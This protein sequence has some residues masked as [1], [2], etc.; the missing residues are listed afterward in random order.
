MTR[1]LDGNPQRV[2]YLSHTARLSGAEIGLLRFVRA[3]RGRVEATVALAEDGDLVAPLREAGARVEVLPLDESARGLKRGEVALGARQLRAAASVSRY[4]LTLRGLIRAVAPDLVHTNSLKAGPYGT[5]AARSARIP[6]VWHLHDH[7]T[8]E[9]LPRRAVTPM[10]LLAGWTPSGLVTPSQSVLRLVMPRRPGM[11]AEA[12]PFPIPVPD[13]PVA[14]RDEARVVG[15]VGRL[16]PWKGQ[17]VFLE[18]FA[19]AFPRGPVRARLIGSAVFGEAD[20]EASLRAQAAR[21]QIADRVEFA[22]FRADIDRAL[23]ELD[24]LVHASVLPDPLPTTVLEG[25][26]AGLP[27]VAADAGGNHEHVVDGVNGL[28]HAPGDADD[29]ARALRRAIGDRASREALGTAAR[30][31][32]RA[33]TEDVVVDRMLDFYRR[34]HR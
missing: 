16:A 9:Y 34:V 17:H 27:V 10:R 18:A 6:V 26:G 12:I 19:R 14:L 3:T 2:L 25:M 1:L 30:R 8:P 31:S 23:P 20:Y 5:A 11:P 15:M 21:L 32:A 7:L 24:V 33:F 22:G 13:A 29:L 28:L 4:A